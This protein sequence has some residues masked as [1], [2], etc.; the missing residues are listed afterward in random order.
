MQS[1]PNSGYPDKVLAEGI[2]HGTRTVGGQDSFIVKVQ[3]GQFRK[4]PG[5]NLT[6]GLMP[7]QS[8]ADVRP[9]Q[10]NKPGCPRSTMS[11]SPSYQEF[12]RY[13]DRLEP[14]AVEPMPL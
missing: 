4:E 7:S 12:L 3:K 2:V 8:E 5:S 6:V 10:V 14:E 13:R 11:L 9:N 1:V